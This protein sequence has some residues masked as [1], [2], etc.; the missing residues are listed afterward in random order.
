VIIEYK[1]IFLKL[2]SS[3]S[4]IMLLEITLTCAIER[5]RTTFQNCLQNLMY[6]SVVEEHLSYIIS[7]RIIFL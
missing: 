2:I 6:P 4:G 1:I 7:P 5:E 3:I